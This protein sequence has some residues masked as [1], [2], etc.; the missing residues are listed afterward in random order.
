MMAGEAPE[1][2]ER[3]DPSPTTQS[4]PPVGR[5]PATVIGTVFWC[6]MIVAVVGPFVAWAWRWGLGL[7]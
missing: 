6:V 4:V 7:L 5:K 3:K 2:G 1:Y